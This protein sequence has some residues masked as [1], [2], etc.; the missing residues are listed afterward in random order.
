MLC[1]HLHSANV[2]LLGESQP[3]N[4]AQVRPCLK[5][6]EPSGA[7]QMGGTVKLTRLP[8]TNPPGPAGAYSSASLSPHVRSTKI[9]YFTEVG[10]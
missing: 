9:R 7:G 5:G 6:L 2:L 1:A 10:M 3:L 8:A 4:V